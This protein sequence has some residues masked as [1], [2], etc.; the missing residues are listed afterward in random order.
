MFSREQVSLYQVSRHREINQLV[1]KEND[2]A[3]QLVFQRY[4]Q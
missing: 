1:K 4:S 2:R 3:E